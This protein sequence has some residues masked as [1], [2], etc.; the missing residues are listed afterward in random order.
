MTA[1]K[2][3]RTRANGKQPCQAPAGRGTDHRGVGACKFHGGAVPVLH[4]RYSRITRPR[5]AA[6]L[7]QLALDPD[8]EDLLPE[9]I[10]IRAL[11]IDFVE[12]YDRMSDAILA[13]HASWEPENVDAL[14]GFLASKYQDHLIEILDRSGIREETQQE[15]LR[16]V[17][18]RIASVVVALPE[19]TKPRQ[20][21]DVISAGKLIDQAGKM[22]E[23]IVKFRS[24]GTITLAT[25]DRVSEQFGVELVRAAQAHISDEFQR[26][27]LLADVEARWGSIRIDPPG[28]GLAGDP[29]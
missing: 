4:G 19:A 12:R 23:R 9:V 16:E 29:A 22:V 3:G 24:Q 13:W 18:R 10:L 6:L 7:A 2:C 20:L 26:A 5:I 21:L 11:I 27:A 1:E 15:I 14:A 17:D 8:P 28:S 25:L